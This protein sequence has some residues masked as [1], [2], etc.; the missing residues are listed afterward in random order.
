MSSIKLQDLFH[1]GQFVPTIVKEIDS[2]KHGYKKVVLSM[3]PK[4]LNA[5]LKVEWVVENMVSVGVVAF[6]NEYILSYA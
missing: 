4:D 2:N 6:M 5:K 1:V 3:D